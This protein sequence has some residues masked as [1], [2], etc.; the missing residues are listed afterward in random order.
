MGFW[1][2]LAKIGGD[3]GGAFVGDPLLGHQVGGVIEGL[4]GAGQ[5]AGNDAAASAQ[6]RLAQAGAQ[7]A[8]D[9]NAIGLFGAKNAAAQQALNQH[10]QL[11]QQ[12]AQGDVMSNVQDTQFSGLPSYIHQANISGGL[13]PSLLGPNA[14]QAG[15]TLSRN[16]LMQ[17]MAGDTNL[18]K[19]PELTPL[20]EASTMDG[21]NKGL[22]RVGAFAGALSPLF[23]GLLQGRGDSSGG[24]GNWWDEGIG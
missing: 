5:V 11:A 4:T 6:G 15:Q 14:R 20:P 21:F 9:R 16:A 10:G 18:P 22:S 24:G 12:A 2:Q 8:Q 23:K 17:L 1:S 7:Q 19:A 13:K 3:I